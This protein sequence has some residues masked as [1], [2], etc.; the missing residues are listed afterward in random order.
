MHE[1]KQQVTQRKIQNGLRKQAEKIWAEKMKVWDILKTDHTVPK[2]TGG[3]TKSGGYY[4]CPYIPILSVT[5]GVEPVKK[6]TFTKNVWTGD[7]TA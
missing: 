5:R 4:Y 6:I 1:T 7:S 2:Y 3:R